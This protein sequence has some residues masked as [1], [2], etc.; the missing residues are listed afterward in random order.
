MIERRRTEQGLGGGVQPIEEEGGTTLGFIA[1]NA[2][3]RGRWYNFLHAQTTNGAQLFDHFINIL[4]VG[5]AL[6]FMIGTVASVSDPK[7]QV[8]MDVFELLS[9]IIFTGEYIL[10]VYSASQD[11]KY[12]GPGGT[13]KYMCTFLA[14]VDL[15][16][17]APYWIHAGITGEF[18]TPITD[19][20][21][22]WSNLVKCLR[23]L[24]LLRF[25][26]TH[27]FMLF[28]DVRCLGRDWIHGIAC[29]GLL[30]GNFILYGTK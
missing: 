29:V 21:S 28:D 6:T 1:N 18:V 27:A 2:S 19:A 22:T 16:T 15:L 13:I 7:I 10:R 20:N 3:P 4:I 30:C 5:T 9:V 24:R 25:E 11:P 17:V 23:L 26:Y 12:S 8:G 14:V